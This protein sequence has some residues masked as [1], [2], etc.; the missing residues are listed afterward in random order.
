[1]SNRLRAELAHFTDHRRHFEMPQVRLEQSRQSARA[2]LFHIA[3]PLWWSIGADHERG[4]F[5]ERILLDGTPSDEPRRARVQARQIYVYAEAARLN[6]AGPAR[7]AVRHGVDYLLKHY[8]R[9]DGSFRHKVTADGDVFDDT[10]DLYDQAFAL[11]ALGHA[12]DVLGDASL[13]KPALDLLDYLQRERALAAGGYT[14]AQSTNTFIKLFANP[15]M[16]LLEAALAWLEHDNDPRWRDFADDL[17]ALCRERFICSQTGCLLEYFSDNWQQIPGPVGHIW[18]PGHHFEWAWLLH[19]YEV[20]TGHDV[21]EMR[22]SLIRTAEE[23][24]INRASGRAV[25]EVL[26]DFTIKSHDSRIWPQ[27]ERLKA[28]LKALTDEGSAEIFAT[29]LANASEASAAIFEYV[30]KPLPGLWYEVIRQDGSF[31]EDDVRAST[32]YHVMGAF[33]ELIRCPYIG[34]QLEN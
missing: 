25:N 20:A 33:A 32:L 4:G 24:G 28:A 7:K 15:H 11:F 5:H 13:K 26:L 3:L 9:G 21:K 19:R 34:S 8:Q 18:E 29:H 30:D 12:A 16:H 23:R 6:W 10:P 2:W 1:M 22:Q 17:V 31:T 27:T 14:E